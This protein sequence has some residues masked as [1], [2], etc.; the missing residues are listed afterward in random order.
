MCKPQNF[1]QS[2]PINKTEEKYFKI[3]I[4]KEKLL[5][6]HD[7]FCQA[8]TKHCPYI[9]LT[10]LP[11][12]DSLPEQ[13]FTRDI[14]IFIEDTLVIGNMNKSIRKEETKILSQYIKSVT[15]PLLQKTLS[16]THNLEG[17][18]VIVVNKTIF[19]GIGNRT[20]YEVIPELE[21]AFPNY[22]IVPIYLMEGFLHLDCVLGILDSTY[23]VVYPNGITKESYELLNDYFDLIPITLKEQEHMATN[24]LKIDSTL[25]CDSRNTRVHKILTNLHYKVITIPFSE[26]SKLGGSLRCCSLPI[27][28]IT[29]PIPL[30]KSYLTYHNNILHYRNINLLELVTKIGNPIKVGYVNAVKDS[31]R[32]LKI[33]FDTAIKK[34]GYHGTYIYANANKANYYSE[35]VT[36]AIKYADMVESSSYMDL[37]LIERVFNSHLFARK[38]IICNGNKDKY[39]IQKI[40]DMHNCGYQ[41]IDVIDSL[42]EYEIL[43]NAS[44]KRKMPIG[45]RINLKNAYKKND[46]TVDHDRFGLTD[47]NLKNIIEH[48]NHTK[49]EPIMLHF[50]QRSSLFDREKSLYNIQ[51]VFEHYYK[52]LTSI[53]PTIYMF[54]LGGGVPYDKLE[55]IDYYKY[56]DEIMELLTKLCEKHHI[57][58]PTLVQENGRYTT[59]DSGFNIYEVTDTKYIDGKLWYIINDSFITSLPNTWALGEE[60][61]ILP[62]NINHELI[63]TLLAGNTCDCD[64]VYYFQTKDGYVLMPKIEKDEPLYIAVFGMGAY[65]EIL[66]GIGGI[67][68]CL[69]LEETD[70]II[71]DKN[72]K[73]NLY[74]IR[75]KQTPTAVMKRLNY[76]KKSELKRFE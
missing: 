70:L 29:Q 74:K 46:K 39:Y 45:L 24:F 25:F 27:G 57:P 1:Y 42:Q 47:T 37:C 4:N 10:Y 65:Q 7:L 55:E 69:N 56:A 50:H 2:E 38:T 62:V 23:A 14:G 22:H 60:F 54:N 26:T 35:I 63:P 17:G 8:I 58:H 18:D 40:I 41:I 76:Y 33:C 36:T 6:E 5:I 9:Q 53:F 19:I 15:L 28:I 16:V 52:K 20:S 71:Y 64:D 73:T 12:Q 30:K 51:Y 3:G 72:Y 43:Q 13:V 59:S 11:N 68:H 61:L 49:L 31:I 66:S 21:H 34:Y 67:H 32:Q 44:L 48:G 75:D